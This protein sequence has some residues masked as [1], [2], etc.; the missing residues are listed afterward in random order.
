LSYW[1][2]IGLSDGISYGLINLA[3]TAQMRDIRP[4]ERIKWTWRN[5]GRSLFNSKH[6]LITI[7]LACISMIFVVLSDVLNFGLHWLVEVGNNELMAGLQ[8]GLING[9]VVGP[10][11]GI[12]VSLSYWCL[13][14]LYQG[15]TQEQIE[16]QDRRVANQGIHR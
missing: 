7:L 5:L 2:S 9:L 4:T 1:L 16:D 14:G 10:S 11:I 8:A 6:L 15:I 3:L 12:S 13:M